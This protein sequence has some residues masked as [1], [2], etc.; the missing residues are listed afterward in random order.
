MKTKEACV[1]TY[2][3]SLLYTLHS[4]LRYNRVGCISLTLHLKGKICKE[5]RGNRYRYNIHASSLQVSFMALQL[6]TFFN[7]NILTDR[8]ESEPRDLIF[9]GRAHCQMSVFN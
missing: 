3:Y 4:I 1:Y 6:Q 8:T 9:F 2:I 5:F 7:F